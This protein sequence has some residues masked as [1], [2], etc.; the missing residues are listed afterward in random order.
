M[1]DLKPNFSSPLPSFFLVQS[2]L[3]TTTNISSFSNWIV[4][5]KRKHI[6]DPLIFTGCSLQGRA[7]QCQPSSKAQ[8]AHQHLGKLNC[9]HCRDHRQNCWHH[10]F[11]IP[12]IIFNTNI[13]NTDHQP[14]S[15][16]RRRPPAQRQQTR[17]GEEGKLLFAT[18]LQQISGSK[19]RLSI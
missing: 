1:L 9:H 19:Q 2:S 11:N 8:Q 3:I 15:K 6:H 12:V 7:R 14:S 4:S 13:T 18:F 16:G 10:C 17:L 5:Y